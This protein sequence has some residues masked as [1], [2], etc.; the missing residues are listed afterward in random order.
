MSSNAY[1]PISRISLLLSECPDLLLTLINFLLR[2]CKKWV[3]EWAGGN[4]KVWGKKPDMG[5]R[6]SKSYTALPPPLITETVHL[7]HCGPHCSSLKVKVRSP[8]V[9]E[10]EELHSITALSQ[11]VRCKSGDS[12]G[13]RMKCEAGVA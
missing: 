6:K 3:S 11:R 8:T 7:S 1:S 9:T 2:G 13:D 12:D 4:D 10:S 5:F